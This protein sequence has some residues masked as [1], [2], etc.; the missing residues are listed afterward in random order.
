VRV[1]PGNR[2]LFPAKKGNRT[3]EENEYNKK[4]LPHLYNARAGGASYFN[5]LP[6]TSILNLYFSTPN[7]NLSRL[8]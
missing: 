2:R 6:E 3:K 7:L 5:E 8:K 1:F 4:P